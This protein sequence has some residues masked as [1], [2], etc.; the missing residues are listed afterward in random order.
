[1]GNDT[2]NALTG[3]NLEFAPLLP[4]DDSNVEL[5]ADALAHWCHGF[6][7]GLV[8]GGLDFGGDEAALSA[9]LKELIRDFG[10]ISK[11]GAAPEEVEDLDRSDSALLELEEYVRVGAQLVF[12]EL[13]RGA[14][15]DLQRTIH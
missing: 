3:L 2:W 15:V 10:E 13:T 5:R 12:E 9:E 11:A 7:A 1:L 14:T 6:L 4:N 8:I